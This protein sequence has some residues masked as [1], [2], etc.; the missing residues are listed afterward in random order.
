MAYKILRIPVIGQ[1]H[2]RDSAVETTE[3]NKCLA[4]DLASLKGRESKLRRLLQLQTFDGRQ[5]VGCPGHWHV[6]SG[7]F[8]KL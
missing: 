4:H 5:E 8:S 1:F 3:A 7:N 2:C 6:N